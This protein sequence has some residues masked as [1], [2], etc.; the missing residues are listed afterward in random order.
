MKDDDIVNILKNIWDG[1][2]VS[3]YKRYT[4]LTFNDTI[5]LLTY[6]KQ[7]CKECF[8]GWLDNVYLII[9]RSFTDTSGF[10][11][12]N[13][14]KSKI[15]NTVIGI[16]IYDYDKDYTST[17]LHE[18][19]H[20]YSEYIGEHGKETDYS[21]WKGKNFSIDRFESMVLGMYRNDK[22][23]DKLKREETEDEFIDYRSEN[24]D[25]FSK[26]IN[27]WLYYLQNTEINSYSENLPKRFDSTL[28]SYPLKCLESTTQLVYSLEGNGEKYLNILKGLLWARDNKKEMEKWT[29]CN[30]GFFG[31]LGLKTKFM[32]LGKDIPENKKLSDF[33]DKSAKDWVDYKINRLTKMFKNFRI[34]CD[35]YKEK[36]R[37]IEYNFCIS[38]NDKMFHLRTNIPS[39]YL[40]YRMLEYINKTLRGGYN[41]YV[42]ITYK[43]NYTMDLTFNNNSLAPEIIKKAEVFSDYII[44]NK[45]IDN[46]TKFN[47]ILKNII[48]K[49]DNHTIVK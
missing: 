36:Y 47:K 16:N 4:G 8:P 32:L 30:G 28:N 34:W 43:N 49:F 29:S 14:S 2:T 48:T 5:T 40:L 42:G 26:L 18:L 10:S 25:I 24:N 17:I 33:P 45:N 20:T 7:K 19:R 23:Y 9:F 3:N 35:E 13:S 6:N 11:T 46:I 21:N 38:W 12:G 22:V 39:I 37:K 1:I 27:Q 31:V 41:I 44:K 15:K